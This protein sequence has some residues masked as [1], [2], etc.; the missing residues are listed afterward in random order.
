MKEQSFWIE[1]EQIIDNGVI[2]SFPDMAKAAGH[3]ESAY[4]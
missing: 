3:L 4:G 2:I 1:D